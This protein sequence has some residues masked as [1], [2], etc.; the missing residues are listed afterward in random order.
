M[1]VP[2]GDEE[3]Y[4]FDS[5]YGLINALLF[6]SMLICGAYKKVCEI[7]N[8]ELKLVKVK[9]TARRGDFERRDLYDK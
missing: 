6:P 2:V 8:K 5:D 9:T 7:V 1:S 3:Y 4:E